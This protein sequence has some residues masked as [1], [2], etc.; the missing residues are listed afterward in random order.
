MNNLRLKKIIKYCQLFGSK[1]NFVHSRFDT[2]L[3]P[4]PWSSLPP[5]SFPPSLL[6]YPTLP[7][8]LPSPPFCLLSLPPSFLLSF[9]PFF[10]PFL[11]YFYFFG[12]QFRI[13]FMS[14]LYTFEL[15]VPEAFSL[16][17]KSLTATKNLQRTNWYLSSFLNLTATTIVDW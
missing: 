9:P 15:V 10:L 8:F 16:S 17:L 2:S 5:F 11:I 6:P 3:P 14:D 12:L 1:I 13:N 4:N 7:S